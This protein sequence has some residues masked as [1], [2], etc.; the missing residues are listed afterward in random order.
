[1]NIFDALEYRNQHDPDK[2]AILFARRSIAYRELHDQAC[3]LS[4]LF[5]QVATLSAGDRVA[6]F[7]PNCPAFVACYY[8]AMHS[9]AIAVSLNVM[10]KH[11]EVKFILE[12][13][14]AKVL[15]TTAALLAQ[16]PESSQLPA[17]KKIFCIDKAERAD[18]FA[19]DEFSALECA[20]GS[21]AE[22]AP[23]DGAAILYTSGT[24]GKPKGALLSHGNIMSNIR[25]VRRHT[26]M[27]CD[28]R[29]ICY[30]PLFHCFGQNFIMNACLDSGAALILHERF[31]PDE[32]LASVK[33]DGVTMFFGVP[34]VYQ[35]LL[36]APNVAEYFRNVRYCFTAAAP[37]AMTVARQW[38]QNTGQIVYEGYGLT[39]TSPFASYNHDSSYREGSVGV[40]LENV[41]MKVADAQG[42][43]LPAGATGEIV[44]K[45]PNV[46]LGYFRRP[47]ETAEAIRDGWFFTGDIGKQDDD[48]YF[49]LVDR[50][51]DMINVAGYKVWPREVEEVLLE[52]PGLS[53][54]AVVG[55]P[56]TK[57]GEAVKAFV[58]PKTGARV[59]EQEIVD[60]GRAHMAAYKAP[61]TVEIID[62]LPRNPAGKVLKREL[63]ERNNSVQGSRVQK[64]DRPSGFP[65]IESLNR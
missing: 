54:I 5:G 56:D 19:L 21:A 17:L 8:A 36:G 25:A 1:M 11:D 50:A 9:G 57:T 62:A 33:S 14:E 35:R 2:E 41:E 24:T 18:A 46:M 22:T 28:D 37:M 32:I 3:R 63:R 61:H 27:T 55:V 31:Q 60:F 6:L 34:P 30:L 44:I 26:Q 20:H 13:C 29:L 16:V 43:A 40:P 4:A 59:T 15:V 10:L 51:K 64:F 39:E 47:K 48:G 53:D 65:K 42:N 12:D 49:Y 7:L 38:R 23:D 52:H 45:G 58:V